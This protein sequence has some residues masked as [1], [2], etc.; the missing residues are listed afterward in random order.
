[1]TATAL[2]SPILPIHDILPELGK[3]LA[4]AP[5]VLLKA[6]PG[7]GKSTI[8][9]LHVLQTAAWL[10]GRSILMLEPRRL[11]ARAAALRMADLLGESVGETVGYSTRLE[12]KVS[13]RT[14]LEV[15]T[16]GILVRRLQKDP[17]LQGIGLV[18]FDEFHERNL[19]ADLGLALCRDLRS[20]L[21]AD[22]KLLL[23]SATLETQALQTA[24]GQPPLVE[25]AGTGYPVTT[26][27]LPVKMRTRQE[28]CSGVAQA[29][30]QALRETR[31]SILAFLPGEAEIRR[32][33]ALLEE[34]AGR[35]TAVQLHPLFGSLPFEQQKAALAPT[36][37][38]QRK[39]VLATNIA[40]SSL[41][42]EGISTVV[43]SGLSRRPTFDPATGMTRLETQPISRASA[44][45][46]RGRAGRLE[47]GI[48]YRLWPEGQDRVRADF[49]PP[50]IKTADLTGL[51]LELA[52]WG[53]LTADDL[54]WIDPP[55]EAALA[56]AKDL[57]VQLQAI[58][59]DGSITAHGRQI[60]EL[61]LEPRY[62]HMIL[63][64]GDFSSE[65]T[66]CDL[67]ALL[68]ERDI[69][70]RT[71]SGMVSSDLR[72]RL[73]LLT[74]ADRNNASRE[75]DRAAE[76]SC[77]KTSRQL[78][79]RLGIREGSSLPSMAGRLVALAYPERVAQKR[80]GQTGRFL[81]RNGRGVELP[82]DDP[83]A[84]E[85]WL[86]V[87]HLDGRSGDSRVFLAAAVTRAD[88][89]EL[90]E[91]DIEQK[92]RVEWSSRAND[93]LAREERCLGALILDS[94]KI[95]QPTS[96]E[97]TAA[98]LSAIHDR[99]LRA[100]PWTDRARR[101]Q[102]RVLFMRRLEP[103]GGWPDVND[104]SLQAR[105]DAWL[106]PYLVG[107][108]SLQEL[109]EL[110]IAAILHSFLD[111][112]QVNRLDSEAPEAVEVPTGAQRSIDYEPE[113]GPVLAVK[114]QE[115]FGVLHTPQVASG[116][117]PLT[118]HLLSP[119]GRP[120]Q[121]T[122]NLE[123]FWKDGYRQVRAEMRGRYPKHAWPEDPL[124][125]KPSTGTKRAGPGRTQNKR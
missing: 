75:T 81:M 112:E 52:A 103:D 15:V 5:T 47:A 67:A 106:S 119:A 111:Q 7:A 82:E 91:A 42:I 54:D 25:T 104:D 92:R 88:L 36:M 19:Q 62:A 40:E 46:R 20:A 23:M 74:E 24:L 68:S 117:L 63:A 97:M 107:L 69:L 116:R 3:A 43:D 121:V 14:R 77:R 38:G 125:A 87:A 95:K 39:V 80:K 93:I 48:C 109:Q 28:I 18:I 79:Q 17:E 60:A 41:T 118:L 65:H 96:E 123:T 64:A 8:A 101:L 32:T 58:R 13:A 22:L 85:D 124:E 76:K 4:V 2:E 71:S 6:A 10:E 27:Y 44:D 45:Q 31:G 70:R 102:A 113:E 59:P 86:A 30:S 66:A 94:R 57:L 84:Q 83:L 12:R 114:L 56:Q 90:F 1:M 34:Q 37:S 115:M 110:D 16:E 72:H 61:G 108:N 98:L 11:A 89:E 73:E 9:P 33:L 50:E 55:P 26:R 100:L 49:D 120:L 99:G 122:Q 21:R 53:C 29:V 51:A 35:H 78:R 105:L